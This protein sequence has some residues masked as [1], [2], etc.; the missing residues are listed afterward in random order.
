MTQTVDFVDDDLL[1]DAQLESADNLADSILDD[2]AAEVFANDEDPDA[3]YFA[4]FVTLSRIL[5]ENGWD[6]EE[7]SEAALT[8]AEIQTTEG[9]A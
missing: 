8:H 1:T 3:V 4:L 6:S 5:A 9:S 7:L 2:I